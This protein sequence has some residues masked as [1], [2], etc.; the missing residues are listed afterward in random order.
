[1]IIEAPRVKYK[2]QQQ[3][4][5]IYESLLKANNNNNKANNNKK[6]NNNKVSPLI[7]LDFNSPAL[8]ASH[9]NKSEIHV[10]YERY[11]QSVNS[12]TGNVT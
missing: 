7:P 4:H 1:M 12:K 8:K 10:L 6:S 2:Q 11:H 9:F 3:Q 5:Q